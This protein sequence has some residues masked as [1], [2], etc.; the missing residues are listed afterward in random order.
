M[1][2][3]HVSLTGPIP[4]PSI[5]GLASAFPPFTYVG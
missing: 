3:D 1:S 4:I 2:G 5:I